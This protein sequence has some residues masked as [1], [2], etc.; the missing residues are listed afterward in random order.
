MRLVQRRERNI[1][2][3]PRYDRV[4][5]QHRAGMI[6]SAVH[7]AMA[8]G[9][10]IDVEFVAQPGA[11]DRHRGR[12][13]RHLLDRIGSVRQRIAAWTTGAKPRAAADAVHLALDLPPQSA[14]AFHREDLELHAGGAG[15]D[16]EDRVHG[17][18]A[19]IAVLRRR[20]LA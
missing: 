13:I 4:V 16:D 5:D 20:A 11:G 8:D 19:A 15:I 9:N 17:S 14:L 1:A 6:R 7:H 2:V 18:H 3:Q 10:G 12:H